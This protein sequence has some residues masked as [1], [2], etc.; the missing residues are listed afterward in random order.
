[1]NV[2]KPLSLL[3][4]EDSEDD[5]ILVI[6]ELR[7]GGYDVNYDRVDSPGAMMAALGQKNLGCH[8]IRLFNAQF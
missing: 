1:M 8:L 6:R 3:L 4:L 7:R 2:K 5:A